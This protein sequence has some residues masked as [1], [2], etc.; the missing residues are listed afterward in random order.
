MNY[1]DLILLLPLAYGLIRGLMKGLINELA[2]L[3]SIVAGLFLAYHYSEEV[4]NW[5]S[6]YF[7]NDSS[8]LAIASYILIFL[9]VSVIIYILARFL[10]KMIHFM[11]LGIVNRIA[12]AIFGLSKILLIML[13]LVYLIGPY[14]HSLRERNEAWQQSKVYGLLDNYADVPGEWLTDFREKQQRDST[15]TTDYQSL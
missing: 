4:Q 13:L 5:L 8:W 14:L 12:G 9:T 7:E 6:Q 1:V 11:A 10:T 3:V 2:S 15:D